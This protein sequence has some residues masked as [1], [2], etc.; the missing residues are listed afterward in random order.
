MA[1]LNIFAGKFLS[2]DEGLYS[3]SGASVAL[4]RHL[5]LPP[6]LGSYVVSG[7]SARLLHLRRVIADSG[8]YLVGGS[9]VDFHINIAQKKRIL[10]DVAMTQSSADVEMTHQRADVSLRVVRGETQ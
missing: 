9:D 10:M 8:I 4:S 6:G 2:T 3:I 1:A 7:Q 5:R